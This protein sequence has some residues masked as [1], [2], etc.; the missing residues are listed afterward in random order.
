MT[1]RAPVDGL[2]FRFLSVFANILNAS[3]FS[4]KWLSALNS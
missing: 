3:F 4:S 2:G 1:N